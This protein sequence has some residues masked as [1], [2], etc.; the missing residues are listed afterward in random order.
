MDKSELNDEMDREELCEL[1]EEKEGVIKEKEERIEELENLVK[2]VKA[3]FENYKKRMDSKIEKESFKAEVDVVRDLLDVVD[4]FKAA[5]DASDGV[6][7][8]GFVE[9]VRNTYNLLIDALE[10]RG[11]SRVQSEEFDP[12]I[13]QAVE[14]VESDEHCDGE[15]VEVVQDG[16]VYRDLV[17]RP[18]LVRVAFNPNGD[19][20]SLNEDEGCDCDE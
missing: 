7:D 17:M 3:D 11:L 12:N 1:V 19:E 8:E 4:S 18:S 10:D 2:R 20:S 13:H 6:E 15:V 9:G 16:Y 5:L 14:R